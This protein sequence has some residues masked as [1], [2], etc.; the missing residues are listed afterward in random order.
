[1]AGG[2]PSKDVAT[3]GG[4]VAGMGAVVHDGG[5]TFRV[6]APH[7]DSVSVV[8]DFNDW[9]P[10]ATPLAPEGNGHWAVDVPVAKPG[11]EYKYH[12]VNGEASFDRIDPQAARVTNSVGNAVIHDHRAF[13][14]QGDDFRCPQHN[15]LVVYELHVG[16]FNR[17][18]EAVGTFDDVLARLDHLAAL[19]VNAVE[20]M[21]VM[22]FAGDLSWG[23]NPAHLFAV[24]S[25]YGGPDKLKE[26]VRTCHQH[27][28]AVLLDVVYNHFGPSDLDLWQFDGWSEDGKGGIYFYQDWRSE[29]PWGDSRPDYGREEVRH[30]IRDNA[31]MWL[32]QYHVDGLRWDMTAYIRSKDS[33]SSDIP[34]GFALMGALNKEVRERFPDK[35]M[36]AEDMHGLDDMVGEGE[37]QAWF[38]AQWDAEFV[39]PLRRFIGAADDAERSM[40]ELRAAVEHDY[41][42]QPFSRVVFTE[43]H[44]EVANGKQRVVADVNPTDQQGWWAAKRAT[45]GAVIALTSPGI[46]MLFQGQEF[47][48]GGWFSDEKPLDWNLNEEHQ[49]IVQLH[50]DVAR[51][52]RNWD[53]DTKG[54]TG[55]GLSVYHVNEA[56]KVMAYQRWY[57]HGIG[58]D[59]VV[60]VNGSATPRGM[61]RI[62][63]P[64][65]GHWELKFNS[66]STVYSPSF[67]S[68]A[69]FDVDA[70]DVP[71]DGFEHSATVELAPYSVLIYSWK[72]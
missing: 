17:P 66:D 65:G 54:L 52:R 68:L 2:A 6:W 1:M 62:G 57:E 60:V 33:M 4:P 13:D 8:G 20:L 43:S 37:G 26:F 23:Y 9:D 55:G 12:L 29:T 40:A 51:L 16:S 71:A 72:G 38:H 41:D 59:V 28:I 47:L 36:I 50:R 32:E 70:Q 48:Q 34:E 27:G 30:F 53:D 24:E 21:P 18:G 56:D 15:E 14:W 58:D 35:I 7:A 22:E 64:A 25:A 61:Y 69:S 19:G 49:G 3:G 39:H 63:L 45:L 10:A 5:V 67:G 11:D 42:D 31:V 44:D 46:P